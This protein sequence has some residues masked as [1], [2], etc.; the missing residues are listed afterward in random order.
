MIL[1]AG[2]LD[3]QSRGGFWFRV[4]DTQHVFETEGVVL[5]RL[6]EDMMPGQD[7]VYTV[8]VYAMRRRTE[9]DVRGLSVA[10]AIGNRSVF[11]SDNEARLEERRGFRMGA[12]HPQSR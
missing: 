8:D 12:V 9:V 10:A 5:P 2:A 3:T 4:T 7:G 11:G 6:E 1:G